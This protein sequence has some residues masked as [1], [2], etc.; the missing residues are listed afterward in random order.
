MRLASACLS[1]IVFC[2]AAPA[3][4]QTAKLVKTFDDWQVFVHEANNEKVCF[5]AS[6]PKESNPK[7]ASRGSIFFYLTTWAKDGVKNEVSVKIGYTFKPDST[8]TLKIGSDK[9]ELYPKEDKA[10]MRDPADER[11]LVD[12]MRKGSSLEL[13]GQSSRGTST[14]DKYSLRGL[15]AA[16]KQVEETCP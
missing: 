14:E 10:F 13:A 2:A 15:S 5:A 6:A 9:F 7:G 3:S 16:L 1:A 11:K 12:A 8:P 4:A